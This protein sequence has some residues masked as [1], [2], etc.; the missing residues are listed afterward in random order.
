[1]TAIRQRRTRAT[2][3]GLVSAVVALI[4][5]V[6]LSIVGFETLADSTAGRQ[7]YEDDQP[8]V[9]QRLPFTSTALIGVADEDGRLTS[10]VAGVLESDGT[11]GSIVQIPVS[12]DPSSGNSATVAPIDAILEIAGPI[13]FREAA[14]RLTG[15][16]FDVIEIADQ[17]RFAQLITPLG[18]MEVNLPG[19]VLDTSSAETWDL[20]PQP[21]T[22][23]AAARLVTA[24]DPSLP[25]W[26]YEPVRTAVWEAI[27][28]RVGAGIG[29]AS[30]VP[31][32]TDL[33]VPSSAD[34]F[35]D[36]LFAGSVQ[37][38]ALQH[39]P[40]D[41]DA[42]EERFDPPYRDAFGPES[43]DAV[44]FLD[45]A[46]MLMVFGGIAPARLGAPLDAP[47]FRIVN[48]LT[49]EDTA[50]IGRSPA[51]LTKTVVNVLM[52]T[53][54]NIV[55]VVDRAEAPAPAV[56]QVRVSDASLLD[57]F[58]AIYEPHFGELEVSIAEVA[59]DGIDAEIV[60]GRS[61]LDRLATDLAAGVAGSP[62]E[63]D[64]STDDS[65]GTGA[66]GDDADD[67]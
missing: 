12:A 26:G 61:F 28:E 60:L 20:G 5:V 45:R 17:Q 64:D 33:P 41:D 27:V 54:T 7:A 15:L 36:R 55:S 25:A 67:D 6:G 50:A 3:L 24:L 62:D 16:S 40:V 23:P 35:V 57:S 47:I 19:V 39:R 59:I 38:R 52:F 21:V 32:D 4:A 13:A 63:T 43:V 49:D 37:F 31:V 8:V 56:T 66:D 29:S 58:E 51:D 42:V 11:G 1:M 10:L 14:E 22:A 46:E 44:V 2:V 18:D 53:K 65:T 48:G 34:E 30:P 9:A